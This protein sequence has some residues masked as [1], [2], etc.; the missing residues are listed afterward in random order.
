MLTI[1]PTALIL[2]LSS[3][4][5]VL[6][7]PTQS[8]CRCYVVDT[9]KPYVPA[10]A[11]PEPHHK[12]DVCAPLGQELEHWRTTD[13][14]IY[15]TFLDSIIRQYP[16][17]TPTDDDL[18]PLPTSVLLEMAKTYGM[19]L[20]NGGRGEVSVDAP[21]QASFHEM[22]ICRTAAAEENEYEDST[23]TLF[24]LCVIV[25]MAVLACATE[26]LVL[27]FSL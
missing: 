22:I 15:Q 23:T 10:S 17:G 13:P 18:K 27:L 21:G 2:L 11:L 20:G 19:G 5:P 1:T 14:E 24:V 4:L 8:R 7:A 25:V 12:N 6:T 26:C 3:V 16:P 9:R